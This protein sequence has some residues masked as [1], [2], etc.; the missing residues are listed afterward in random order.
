MASEQD[1]FEWVDTDGLSVE[2]IHIRNSG[3]PDEFGIFDV[4]EGT[5]H[6]AWITAQEGSFVDLENRQ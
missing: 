5:A 3:E 2:S 1:T 6:G 4:R